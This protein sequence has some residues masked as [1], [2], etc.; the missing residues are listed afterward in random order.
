MFEK[1][2]ALCFLFFCFLPL[3]RWHVH[4]NIKPPPSKYVTVERKFWLALAIQWWKIS[5]A[6]HMNRGIV[7]YFM[8]LFWSGTCYIPVHWSWWQIITA[9][10][11]ISSTCAKFSWLEMIW[12]DIHLLIRGDKTMIE[13]FGLNAH[14]NLCT[15][16]SY[17]F[18]STMDTL[19]ESSICI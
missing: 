9:S 19:P 16:V 11:F 10:Y 6:C 14:M 5:T 12:K 2:L 4:I 1:V 3:D 15:H 17:I 13:L 18:F 7:S 8:Q